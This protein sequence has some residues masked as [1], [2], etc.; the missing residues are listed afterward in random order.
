MKCA[1]I[2]HSNYPY[3]RF[4]ELLR[5]NG[6]GQVIDVRSSPYSHAVP[7]YDRESLRSSLEVSGV[8]YQF[9]GDSL[10]ARYTEEGLLFPDGR[11]DFSKVR[12]RPAFQLALRKIVMLVQEGPPIALMCAEKEPYDCHRFVLVS[13]ALERSGVEVEHILDDGRPIPNSEL[14][15]RLRKEYAQKDLF[16]FDDGAEQDSLDAL[17]EKRN[18]AIA[19]RAW[20]APTTPG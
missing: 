9:M 10:G 18:K 5:L 17:Y 3:D 6:I 15:K 19:Y 16:S 7:Q 12:G 4:L 8:G 20:A 14:E 11:V 13:Y 1:T 2:G